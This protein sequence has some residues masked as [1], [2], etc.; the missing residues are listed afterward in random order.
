MIHVSQK[1]MHRRKKSKLRTQNSPDREFRVFREPKHTLSTLSSKHDSCVTEKYAQG[2]KSKLR[3]QNSPDREFRVFREP[4]HT[5]STLSSK[6]DSC[7]TEKYAQGKKSKL[8]TQNSPDREFRV[9]RELQVITMAFF[10]LFQTF[11]IF[12]THYE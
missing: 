8:R 11:G 3:T 1:N 2:K 9:F 4:K 7:V 12:T 5:L 6:H 10:E